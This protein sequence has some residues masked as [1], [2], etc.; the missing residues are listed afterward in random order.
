MENPK[1]FFEEEIVEIK[2]KKVS[3][4]YDEPEVEKESLLVKIIG[5]L[6]GFRGD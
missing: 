5:F 2:K 6:I 4:V 1:I 3:I